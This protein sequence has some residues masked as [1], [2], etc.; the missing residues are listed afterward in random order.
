[1]DEIKIA[2]CAECNNDITTKDKE[3]FVNEDGEHFCSIDCVLEHYRIV[4]LE[5]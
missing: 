3:A 4:R 2:Y 5:I 1:M